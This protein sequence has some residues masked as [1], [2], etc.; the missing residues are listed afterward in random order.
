MDVVAL[1]EQLLYFLHLCLHGFRLVAQI[2]L[3]M[4]EIT[5]ELCLLDCYW[6]NVGI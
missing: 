2:L 3:Q 6:S 5:A 1:V 4:Q